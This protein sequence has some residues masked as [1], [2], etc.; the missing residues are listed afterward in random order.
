MS[1]RGATVMA[2]TPLPPRV[3]APEARLRLG[4]CDLLLLGTV[5]GFAPDAERVRAA[6]AAHRPDRL[7]LGV[8]P[9]D[10]PT[11]RLLALEPH[12]AA[13]LPPLHEEEAHL[14]ALLGRFGETRIPSPDLEAAE[15]CAAAANVPVEALDLDDAAHAEA[16][17]KGMK[18]RHLVRSSGRRK[19]AL[20]SGFAEAT[21]AYDLAARWD[22]LLAIGPLLRLERMR[23]GHMAARLRA[24]AQESRSLLAVVPAARLPG[25][26]AALLD[27][28]A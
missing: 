10:L 9:E 22:A 26:A 12:R 13:D 19:Q 14:Q 23:E 5:A 16:Y 28:P 11:L 1:R 7:A 21:D 15:R 18:V 25:V 27:P 2:A 4:A 24:L 20:K 17:T 6:F 8:P 3:S